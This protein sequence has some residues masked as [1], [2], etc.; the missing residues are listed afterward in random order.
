MTWTPGDVS[1]LEQMTNAD[2]LYVEHVNE[3]RTSIDSISTSIDNIPT[4]NFLNVIDYGATGDGITDDYDAIMATITALPDDGGVIVFPVGT[5]LINTEIVKPSN[6]RIIFRGSGMDFDKHNA[7]GPYSLPR[8]IIKAGAVMDNILNLTATGGDGIEN[9]Q[10]DGDGKANWLLYMNTVDNGFFNNLSFKS[11]VVGGM[12]LCGSPY[13]NVNT[14]WNTFMNIY[15]Q[16]IILGMLLTYGAGAS[17]VCHNTF[18]NISG[19][20]YGDMIKIIDADGN[21][22]FGV[23][24]YPFGG[25]TLNLVGN[26]ARD[27][28]FYSLSGPINIGSLSHDNKVFG[29]SQENGESWPTIPSDATITIIGTALNLFSSEIKVHGSGKGFIATSPNGSVTKRISIDNSGN[30]VTTTV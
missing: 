9:M 21:R 17:N 24:G 27:N 5:F 18:I 20:H 16:D 28:M 23:Y 19:T 6:K 29:F 12:Y 15:F 14:T 10:F 26:A 1:G 2:H 11:A 25:Y 22:F 30:V 3:L 4:S 13:A 8:T 7:L